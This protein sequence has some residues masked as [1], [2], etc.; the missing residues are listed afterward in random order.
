MWPARSVEDVGG[1]VGG[2]A[3]VVL[4]GVG[5]AT[6]GGV[7][8]A[9]SG[10]ASGAEAGARA[11]YRHGRAIGGGGLLGDALGI[12]GGLVEGVAGGVGGLVGGGVSGA[13]EGGVSGARSGGAFGADVAGS[14]GEAAG[15]GIV[16]A[17]GALL[18]GE[19]EIAMLLGSPLLKIAM[20]P[21]LAAI[22][23][24]IE[25]F[26]D[27]QTTESGVQAASRGLKGP[28]HSQLAK[29]APDHPLFKVSVALAEDA[30]R[31]IGTAIQ[32][33]WAA[34]TRPAPADP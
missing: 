16:T 19:A 10:A 5:G 32:A 21:Y 14:A 2:G 15:R 30:D 8:G 3:G 18:L 28:T 20:V 26:A 6:L 33:A 25:H 17:T 34:R 4:G 24:I 31:Q 12:A 7:E 27:Q 11:G 13:V 23:P 22:D 1:A 9:A 29:D